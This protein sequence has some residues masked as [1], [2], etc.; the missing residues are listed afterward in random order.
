TSANEIA[1]RAKDADVILTNKTPLDAGVI[2]GLPKLR[3]AGVLAT[4]YNVVDGKALRSRGIP[5]SNVPGYGTASVA[6]HVFALLLDLTNHV[7]LHS[8]GVH[9]SRW[10]L[11]PDFC[12]WEKPLVEL[13]TLNFGV[14]GF[15]EIAQA[16]LRI[17]HGFGMNLL[18][19]SRTEKPFD[20][21]VRFVPLD[22]LAK[23]SDV[24]S[25]HCPLTDETK[26]MVN[27]KFLSLMKPTAYLLNTGR[28]AL[29][30]GAHLAE[31]LRFG[32][33]AGAGIDVMEKE[34]PEP[35][36]PLFGVPNCVI[37]PHIAWATRA[38]RKR[39]IEKTAEN[40]KAFL[41]GTPKNVVN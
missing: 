16:A 40:I 7:S 17:A 20:L 10:S 14:V 30:N 15:G 36:H 37:T 4:G 25:L 38:A 9:R 18:V 24:L 3:Y 1:S 32:R 5:L 33:I 8:A 26:Y 23:K 27:E 34:P 13:S 28:G 19:H 6:Q 31:A 35:N 22:E 12:Y 39:L 29:V 2:A 21:P 11:S 41:E